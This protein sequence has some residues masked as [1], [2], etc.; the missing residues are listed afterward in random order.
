MTAVSSPEPGLGRLY[1]A[2]PAGSE[3]E[4]G[5]NIYNRELVR[6]LARRVEVEVFDASELGA[7]I[8][9]G[10]PGI[11]FVDTLNLADAELFARRTAGQRFVLI[12]HHLPSLEPDLD[13]SDPALRLEANALAAFDLFLATS[14][15]TAELLVTRGFGRDRILTVTPGVVLAEREPAPDITPLRALVVGNL[16]RRKAAL[17]WLEALAVE[18]EPGDRFELELVGRVDLEP[19]YARACQA[20]IVRTEAFRGRVRLTGSVPYSDMPALYRCA[21]VLVAP[22][23]ME[24]FG[25]ALQEARAH[26]LW[27]LARDAGNARAHVQEGVNGRLLHSS[28]ALARAFL[29]LV[30]SPASACAASSR[31]RSARSVAGESWAAAA[32]RLLS[33]LERL[34]AVNRDR[35]APSG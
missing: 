29:E 6:E 25:M 35:A 5:G 4:S 33:E 27:I 1:F 17:E 28:A 8:G 15:F 16:I 12:V 3:L 23:R 9:A 10:A 24:T 26:G 2:L 14:V 7:R 18:L 21:A 22:S 20:L 19:E 34:G 32:E 31:A 13:P 30:R 11:Y